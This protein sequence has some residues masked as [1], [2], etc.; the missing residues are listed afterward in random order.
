MVQDFCLHKETIRSTCLVSQNLFE[1]WGLSSKDIY[2]MVLSLEEALTNIYEHGYDQTRECPV[3][4]EIFK[5][6][7]S[8]YIIIAD[9]AKAFSLESAKTVDTT[10]YLQ[11]NIRGGFGIQ[12]IKK[13][14]DQVC[15]FPLFDENILIM[16]KLIP[17]L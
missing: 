6:T 10:N 14:M 12:I 7:D 13:L 15:L 4:L 2:D 5:G 8:V 3:S 16:T 17:A 1:N 9:H 11:S